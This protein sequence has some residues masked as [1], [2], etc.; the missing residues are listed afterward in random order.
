MNFL[1]DDILLKSPLAK[2]LYSF[3]K[4]QPIIDYH[5]HID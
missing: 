1:N 2:E 3:A 5:C 4:E